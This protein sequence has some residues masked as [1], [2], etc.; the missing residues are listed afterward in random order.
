MLVNYPYHFQDDSFHYSCSSYGSPASVNS[1]C[2]TGS[3]DTEHSGSFSSTATASSH[4]HHNHTYP[5][6]PGQTPREVSMAILFPF[7]HYLLLICL[8]LDF[9]RCLLAEVKFMLLMSYLVFFYFYT[10]V[11]QD[12]FK[13]TKLLLSTP[14]IV[15]TSK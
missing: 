12:N 2:S 13:E 11:H 6:Q 1:N 9:L 14:I 4:V 15:Q 7:E 3:N 5:T 10:D 8:R